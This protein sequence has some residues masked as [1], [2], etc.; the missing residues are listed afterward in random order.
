MKNIFTHNYKIFS[1]VIILLLSN[2]LFAQ[3]ANDLCDEATNLVLAADEASCVWT[4]GDTRM[5]VNATATPSQVVCSGSWY[6]DDV[7]YSVTTGATVPDNGIIVKVDFGTQA[8]DVTA[9]GMAL[10][11]GCAVTD[12]PIFCFSDGSG[13]LNEGIAQGVCLGPNETLLIRIWSG[14]SATD[15]SGTF[16]I[17]T[18]ENE[19]PLPTEASLVLWE[20]NFEDSMAVADTW[21]TTTTT[22]SL[23]NWRWSETG[24]FEE[25]N[26]DK[27]ASISAPFSSCSSAMGFTGGWY[28]T[29]RTGDGSMIP[30]SSALY[31]DYTA[32]LISPAIDL[33]L[34]T[35]GV[36]VQFDQA[37]RKLNPNAGN[38][39]YTSVSWSIDDGATWSTPVEVNAELAANDPIKQSTERVGLS[40]AEGF[41]NVK[42][43]FS[44]QGD[45]Y[46]WI[47]DRVKIV[48]RE[49]HNLR[50]NNFYAIAPNKL[51]AKTQTDT[52]RF[53][54]DV[55]N[56]GNQDQTNAKVDFT[57]TDG[58][59]AVAYNEELNY[60]TIPA[61]FLDENR[62]FNGFYIPP[63]EVN[64]YTGVYTVSADSVDFD[65]TDNMQQYTFEVT[66]SVMAKEDGTGL[67]GGTTPGTVTDETFTMATT[68]FIPN[69]TD[70]N[71]PNI[72]YE[73]SSVL[74]SLRGTT[75]DN[76]GGF[77][78]VYLYEWEDTDGD[79][80]SQASERPSTSNIVGSFTYEIQEGDTDILLDLE[81]WDG[82]TDPLLLKDQTT[83]VLALGLTPP[84]GGTRYSIAGNT[85]D[86]Y[87]ATYFLSD[88]IGIG[89][90]TA[91]WNTTAGDG[92]LD[93]DLSPLNFSPRLR[94]HIGE[95]EL[96]NVNTPL[97]KANEVSVFP[98]PANELINLKLDLVEDLENA[99][100]RI[101]NTNA[102]TVF[103]RNYKNLSS[104][105][106]EYSVS[107]L[108][109][110]NYFLKI[111]SDKGYSTQK[112]TVV[113]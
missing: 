75:A 110:G 109:A 21:E 103:E 11:L 56:V 97:D 42:V 35:A 113:R 99:T 55:E 80:T 45:F 61:I 38:I 10:Y 20:E 86:D 43:K 74:I 54:I 4:D 15:N 44:F 83:Y 85:A 68:Y 31:E 62:I 105:T 57:M 39:P 77:A 79:G 24:R 40:G 46:W 100:V 111:Q 112:F 92:G 90:R 13:T 33:S 67:F 3:P 6:T 17:C 34:V 73:C 48:E 23:D 49:A 108:P 5:T 107:E 84:T 87:S 37:V 28:Q 65:P 69:G 66:D 88:S 96:V 94:M 91:L 81:N 63:A 30:A 12:E 52:I 47:I 22:D 59:G 51:Q 2:N 7:W 26:G 14:G 53:L 36:S 1:F 50:A 106:F 101:I 8:D 71:D 98:N 27:V 41:P 76:A 58:N 29:N 89:R 64:T 19:E 102:Q 72:A 95:V 16:R 70:P 9:V 60:G 18:Y 25:T 82:S 32:E 78:S 104:Q 93:S